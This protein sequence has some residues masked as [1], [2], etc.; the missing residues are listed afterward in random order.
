M[1]DAIKNKERQLEKLEV[2]DELATKRLS[3]SQKKAM[4]R[5]A[6]QKYGRDWKKILGGALKSI[7]P[8]QERVQDLY[9]M[10]I[11]GEELRNMNRPD[12]IGRGRNGD[13]S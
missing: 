12:R 4:E 2:D 9:S 13:E 11:G 5:E 3:I 8:N 6:K 1:D 10:G 7:R